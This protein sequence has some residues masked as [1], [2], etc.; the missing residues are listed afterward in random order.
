VGAAESGT[1][2]LKRQGLKI[3]IPPHHAMLSLRSMTAVGAGLFGA[4][5]PGPKDPG[6]YGFAPCRQVLELVII[7]DL[8]R[9]KIYIPSLSVD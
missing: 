6:Y 4:Y 9:K 5:S 7:P 3:K 1:R 2:G 8:C